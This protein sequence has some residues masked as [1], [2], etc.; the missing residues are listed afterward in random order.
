MLN[1]KIKKKKVIIIKGYNTPYR[2]ELFNE[3]SRFEDIELHFV[4]VG[5][6]TPDRKWTDQLYHEFFEHQVKLKE[7][8]IKD[9]TSSYSQ[10]DY[11]NFICTIIKIRPFVIIDTYFSAQLINLIPLQILLKFEFI[12]WNESTMITSNR[13][14]LVKFSDKLYSNIFKSYLVPGIMA[15]NYLEYAGFKINET[16]TF[17]A[18]NSVDEIFNCNIEQKV[19][20]LLT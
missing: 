20:S 14:K 7:I 16:N 17:I 10:P 19:N 8:I 18:P 15:K 11:W 9:Y 1:E 6:R 3:I 4:Y 2:N 5:V 13:N 12:Y